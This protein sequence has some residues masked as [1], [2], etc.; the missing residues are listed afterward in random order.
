MNLLK[1][2]IKLAL[3][4]FGIIVATRAAFAFII[5]VYYAYQT[6]SVKTDERHLSHTEKIIETEF[7][8]EENAALPPPPDPEKSLVGLMG[9][10]INN[11]GVRDD[12]ER[13]I[14][15]QYNNT[16]E[17]KKA[18]MATIRFEQN[19]MKL[20]A[21]GKRDEAVDMVKKSLYWMECSIELAEY[22]TSQKGI[23]SSEPVSETFR[24]LIK[25]INNTNERADASAKVSKACSGHVFGGEDS[26]IET[27]RKKL[28]LEH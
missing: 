27:C 23:K 2:I 1:K 5:I 19:A 7:S 17:A 21:E 13:I 28:K 6:D 10:D 20:A 11:N 4:A 9:V 18:A 16:P 3:L 24:Y 26:S 15:V 12:L 14:A 22:E 25:I 8:S